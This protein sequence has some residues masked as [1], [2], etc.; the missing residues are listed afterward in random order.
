MAQE[1]ER[2][3]LVVGDGWRQGAVRSERIVDGLLAS[4]PSGKVRVRLYPD[5]ATLSVKTRKVAGVRQEFEYE[6]PVADARRLLKTECGGRVLAKT[7]FYTPHEG[8]TWEVD[9]YDAPLEGVVLAEVE[10]KS[11]SDD[12]PL[13]AW[14]GRDVTHDPAFSKRQM[15]FDRTRG[16]P[17]ILRPGLID[18]SRSLPALGEVPAQR[19]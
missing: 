17:P 7:R 14:A 2:K 6:I 12:P 11:L 16:A 8:F 4:A 15:F 3:F 10:L 19:G 9:V 1:I 5:R 18:R 13:P